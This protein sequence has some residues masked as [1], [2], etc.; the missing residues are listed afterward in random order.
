MKRILI[1]YFLM[2]VL[3]AG[4]AHSGPRKDL[5][6]DPRT[7]VINVQ[8][9][10]E[11]NNIQSFFWNTG[12]FNQDLRTT[13]TPGFYWPKGTGHAAIF[14]TGLSI[15][16]Y[17]QG[18]LRAS[19]GSYKGEY[20]PG[21]INDQGALVTN[22]KFKIYTV[23]SGD[24]EFT[25]PDYANWPLMIPYGAPYVDIDSNGTYTQGVDIPGIKNAAQ[26]IF[27]CLTDGD[28]GQHTSSE[29]FGGG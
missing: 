25:N 10:L 5:P 11:G 26:T 22:S 18:S 4:I 15:C 27:V 28:P 23:K 19:M 16:A 9:P 12:V 20:S 8:V 6:L 14:T 21:Y 24:N 2:T 29:G 13:D 1:T 7:S 3:F 17:Y